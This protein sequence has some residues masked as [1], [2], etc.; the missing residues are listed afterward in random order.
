MLIDK[1]KEIKLTQGQVAVVDICDYEELNQYKW[2]ALK[3]PNDRWYVAR[4][5]GKRTIVIHRVIM[6]CPEGLVVDHINHDGLDNRRVNLRICTRAQNNMNRRPRKNM[7]SKYKGVSW[8]KTHKVWIARISKGG[9]DKN[10]GSFDCE[11]KAAHA[12]NDYVKEWHGEF[13][14]LNVIEGGL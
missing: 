7:T 13:G 2:H 3:R 11:I 4:W 14:Y 5:D 8:C 10:V 1:T 6:D 12:Y 9:I